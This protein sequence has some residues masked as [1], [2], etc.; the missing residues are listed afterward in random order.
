MRTHGK[1][2]NKL[3]SCAVINLL[4]MAGLLADTIMFWQ[5]VPDWSNAHSKEIFAGVMFAQR[6]S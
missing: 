4:K 2:R 3:K 5:R 1:F 6:D